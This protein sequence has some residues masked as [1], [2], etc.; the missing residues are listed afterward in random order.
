MSIVIFSVNGDGST[1]DVMDW[2]DYLGKGTLRVNTM[3]GILFTKF[4]SAAKLVKSH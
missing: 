2:I 4:V 3:D 1:S